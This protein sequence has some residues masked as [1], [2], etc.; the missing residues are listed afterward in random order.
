MLGESTLSPCAAGCS[1]TQRGD[2]ITAEVVAEL[3]QEPIEQGLRIDGGGFHQFVEP[4][5]G[6]W[7]P[8]HR[9]GVLGCDHLG[10]A[11]EPVDDVRNVLTLQDLLGAE[12]PSVAAG[13]QLGQA[14]PRF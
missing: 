8:E 6:S 7:V 5:V 11:R 12:E 2:R 4:A 13:A 9:A 1:G 10:I 3:P 14:E